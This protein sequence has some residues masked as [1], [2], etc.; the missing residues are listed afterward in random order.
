[1]SHDLFMDLMK[2]LIAL[3]G[4][5]VTGYLIPWIKNHVSESQMRQLDYYC[6]VAVRCAEQ[7]FTPEQFN[8]KKQY[9]TEYIRRVVD[10]RLSIKITD[11]DI[12]LIVEGVVNAIKKR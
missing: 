5:L 10:A 2:I 6:S 7:I 4:V 3:L 12:D 11:E 9:V 8:E 1:M